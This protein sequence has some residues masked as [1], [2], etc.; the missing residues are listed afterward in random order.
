MPPRAPA[1]AAL[2]GALYGGLTQLLFKTCATAAVQFVQTG[3]FPWPS[4]ASCSKQLVCAVSCAV[5]QA[6]ALRVFYVHVVCPRAHARVERTARLTPHVAR[7]ARVCV[8]C[9]S[10]S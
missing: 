5:G 8:V 6:R 1:H 7:C 2:T 9:R 3:V 4:G 10:S